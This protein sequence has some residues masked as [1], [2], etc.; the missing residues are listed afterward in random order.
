MQRRILSLL[1]GFKSVQLW[2]VDMHIIIVDF[3]RVSFFIGKGC[4]TTV[5]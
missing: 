5:I 4:A 3:F 1:K 2:H